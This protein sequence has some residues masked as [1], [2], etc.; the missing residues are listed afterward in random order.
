MKIE[1]QKISTGFQGERCFV[2]ARGAMDAAGRF[3]ITAQPLR[4]SG[5]DIFYGM[6]TIQSTDGGATWSPFVP[7][8]TLV[9]M[10]HAVPGQEVCI[11]DMTPM[12]Q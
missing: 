5:S 1:L 6:H 12:Y 8:K 11:C 7:S 4:L 10:P 9:R 2:H 3:L